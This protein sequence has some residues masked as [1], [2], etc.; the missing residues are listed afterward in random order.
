MYVLPRDA[1]CLVARTRGGPG[2]GV[3]VLYL[4]E[5]ID[6]PAINSLSEFEGKNFV[7]VSR[8]GLDLAGDTEEDKK[9]VCAPF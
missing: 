9:K 7:D 6:E 8:E 2:V 5:P 1:R 3:Q 4:T